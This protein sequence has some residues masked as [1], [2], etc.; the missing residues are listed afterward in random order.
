MTVILARYA[1]IGLK[2]TPVRVKFENQLKDN[3]FSMLMA[4]GVEAMVTKGEA[5]FFVEAADPDTAVRSLRK[6][7]GIASLSVTEQ[8]TSSMEDMC[9]TAAEY[10]MSRLSEGMSFAVKAR[11][12]GS[13]PYTSVDVG[14]EVGSAI[15]IA[16]ESKGVK[17][18][19]TDPD[20][21][22][23]VEIRDNRAYVF[24]SY[25]RCHAGLPLGSQGKVIATVD[26]DRAIV[27]AWL[28]MKRGCRAFVEGGHDDSLLLAYDPNLRRYEP[29]VFNR[30][31][32]GRVTGSTL[33][34]F[35]QVDVS[36]DLPVFFPTIGMSDEDV[37]ALLA[38]MRSEAGR[39]D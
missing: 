5:R 14:R 19:L 18:D 11:R 24:D 10:S 20:A 38:T 2:S 15:F 34:D 16:N 4:D 30:E 21:V 25:I 9:A 1:E 7:F 3:M 37:G 28:M 8:C 13:H 29:S 33:D 35:T 12:E 27:A 36:G 23:Y 17:V 26:S 39:F 31:F 6:V 22:F 32:L